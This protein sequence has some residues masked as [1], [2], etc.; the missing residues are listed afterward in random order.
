MNCYFIL[1]SNPINES[2][3]SGKTGEVLQ[4]TINTRMLRK[5]GEPD[6]DSRGKSLEKM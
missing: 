5:V 4:Q 2:S 6:A 1:V 3:H